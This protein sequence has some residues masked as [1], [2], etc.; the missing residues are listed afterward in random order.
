MMLS[1]FQDIVMRG[2]FVRTGL[3][4]STLLMLAV[5]GLIAQ[6]SGR[7]GHYEVHDPDLPPRAEYAARRAA[8][9]KAM[10]T[11]SA[12]LVRAAEPLTRS[13]DVQ[14][15]LR[16]RNSM[17]YLT[18]VTESGSALLLIPRGVNVNGKV[19]NEILFVGVR[20]PVTET[21][22]GPM[23]GP[24]VA[25][26][27]T[28]IATVLPYDRL[29]VLLDS[30][31]PS[32]DTLYYDGWLHGAE[33][34]PLT[35][36]TYVWDREM[37][38]AKGQEWGHLHV[39]NAALILNGMRVIKS[40]VEQKLMQKAVEISIEAHRETI[41]AARTGMYEYELEALME[42]HFHRLGSE[43]PGY[44]SIVGSGPNSCIL[45]YEPNRRKT[46]GGDLVLMDCG[47]E[48]HGYSADIT[49]TIPINGKFTPEQR[50]IYDIV[51]QAQKE[52]ID[53][54][55]SGNNFLL[56]HRKAVDVISAGL[57]RLGIIEE[58]QHYSEYFLHGTSH[59][60]GMDVHDVGNPYG[61]L[62]PGMVLTVEP[63]IYIPEGSKCDPKW[64]NIGIRIEDNVIVT[65]GAP[66][67]LTESLPHTADE[68]EGLMST[69]APSKGSSP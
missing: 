29:R 67:N 2:R 49:R 47:A 16:Q 8:V 15:E 63:A 61:A 36:I 11:S 60:L 30:F 3:R 69:F 46:V 4:V 53:A 5:S 48:Y 24:D 52:A 38:K 56:P 17:L 58:E 13:N 55:R 34:E 23:M 45:H 51:L 10:D 19:V 25:V 57:M 12:M 22:M 54:C 40:P 66:L 26:A 1:R 35:G 18:G 31:V 20:N 28:G 64:W 37:K 14:Y 44:P 65:D 39:K 50:A 21:W 32:L 59:Y 41:R 62:Q 42:Y 9:L 33:K 68:I 43:S 27:V 6:E 7:Y